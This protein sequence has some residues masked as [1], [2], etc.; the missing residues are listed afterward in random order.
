MDNYIVQS[1]LNHQLFYVVLIKTLKKLMRFLNSNQPGS[2]GPLEAWERGWMQT[3]RTYSFRSPFLE[4]PGNFTGP[5]S[6][7]QIEI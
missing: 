4:S 6:N 7:I 2:Q 1:H 5:K 3:I